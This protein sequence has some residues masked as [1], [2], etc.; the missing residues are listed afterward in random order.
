M[1]PILTYDEGKQE[2]EETSSTSK[3]F[4]FGGEEIS[5]D[6]P[7]QYYTCVGCGIGK[8]LPGCLS[9]KNLNIGV[10]ALKCSAEVSFVKYYFA[11]FHDTQIFEGGAKF[12]RSALSL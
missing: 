2:N 5:S 3:Q 7:G 10:V 9:V 4:V 11:I 12:I 6:L 1:D 8:G